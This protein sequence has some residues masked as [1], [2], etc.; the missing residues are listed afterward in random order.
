MADRESVWRAGSGL[1]RQKRQ[2]SFS[3]LRRRYGAVIK[4]TGTGEVPKPMTGFA[5]LGVVLLRQC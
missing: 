3:A 2:L 5:P 1:R 4:R